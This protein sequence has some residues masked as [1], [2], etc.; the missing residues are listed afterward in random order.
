M[1]KRGPALFVRSYNDVEPITQKDV[2]IKRAY[3]RDQAK[4]RLIQGERHECFQKHFHQ[5]S[6]NWTTERICNAISKDP[7]FARNPEKRNEAISNILN[8]INKDGNAQEE[9]NF[10][11][12][13]D[14]IGDKSLLGIGTRPNGEISKKLPLI[15]HRNDAWQFEKQKGAIIQAARNG[16]VIVSAFISQKERDIKEQLETELLPLVEII[17]NGITERYK[18]SGK[19]FFA[20]AENRLLQITPWNHVYQE[21]TVVSREMCLTMNELTRLICGIEDDWWKDEA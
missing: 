11:V 15:C 1:S 14:Y 21:K 20:M 17:D 10:P 6:R 18:P 3:I 2:E 8:R 5:H 4:K 12:S 19:D 9:N 13:L 7:F 16:A